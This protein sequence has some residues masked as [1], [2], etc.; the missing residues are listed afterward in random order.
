[1]DHV[2]EVMDTTG[3][4]KHLWDPGNYKEV[5][6]MKDLFKSLTK[7]GYIA[8]TVDK[9]DGTK[10]KLIKKFDPDAGRIILS[11]PVVGG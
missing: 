2:M 4:S 11:P 6:A 9:K 1:M 10:G 7:K 8:Y 5:E 3:D